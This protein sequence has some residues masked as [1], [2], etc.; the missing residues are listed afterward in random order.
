MSY[1]NPVAHPALAKRKFG[2]G[3][4]PEW[5]KDPGKN[6]ENKQTESSSHLTLNLGSIQLHEKMWNVLS[7]G[8]NRSPR[9]KEI[10]DGKWFSQLRNTS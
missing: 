4:T 3:I 8:D 1:Q 5:E 7:K 9:Y 10:I 6:K 2:G